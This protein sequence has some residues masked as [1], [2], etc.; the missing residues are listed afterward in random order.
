MVTDFLIIG[1]GI[2]GLTFAVKT[3]EKYPAAN[4]LIITKSATG[5]GNTRYAQG[6]IAVV[7]DLLKDS[8]EKHIADTMEAGDYEN[9]PE[10]V[11][12]VVKEA[13]ERIQELIKWG[14]EFDKAATGT[15]DAGR[16]GGHSENRVIHFKDITG[17]HV[18]QT[19][20]RKCR[21]LPNITLLAGIFAKDIL[22]EDGK[23]V[24][25]N[26][27]HIK[28]GELFNIYASTTMLATGGAGQIYAHTTNPKVAT[29]DGVAMAYRAGAQVKDMQYVQF[30]PTAL[31][32]PVENPSFLISEAVRGLGG[33]LCNNDGIAFMEKYHYRGSLAPRDVVSRAIYNEMQLSNQPFVYLDCTNI[34]PLLFKQ[35]FPNILEKCL[36]LNIDPAIDFIPVT[37][38]AH[39]FCGGVVV[40]KN[41][42]TSISDLYACGECTCTG[43]HGANR[44]A[45]NSL[46]EG[47][48]YAHNSFLDI[49]FNKIKNRF[50]SKAVIKINDI[51]AAQIESLKNQLRQVMSKKAGIVKRSKDLYAAL[52]SVK[53]LQNK[54]QNF[55]SQNITNEAV[56]E[57]ENLLLNSELVLLQ[58]LD[59]KENKGTF[60]NMDLIKQ[61]RS[62]LT[63]S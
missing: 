31:F 8:F 30:H 12:M 26:A 36:F 11:E 39:Y 22:I 29:G 61:E 13:P 2:A 21:E 14:A 53:Q 60:F 51:P 1:S 23:C 41:G 15:L 50:N 27:L 38:A 9:D 46:L 40:D 45:S 43:L 7:T 10:V 18:E 28:K 17:Y 55:Q 35:H 5:E 63:I 59:Q 42:S 57:L 37:P 52:E 3:A 58:S 56:M 49:Q 44:L 47:L 54:L 4:V 6:G 32:A 19:L 34:D 24:G 16:E 20:L 33:I 48:V 62:S 25:A